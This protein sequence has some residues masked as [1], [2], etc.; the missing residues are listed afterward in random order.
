[1]DDPRS[2]AY[3]IEKLLS[4]LTL[5]SA[6]PRDTVLEGLMIWAAIVEC[7]AVAGMDCETCPIREV[8]PRVPKSQRQELS[9]SG[10]VWR[11]G[12]GDTLRRV[13]E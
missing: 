12:Q 1:M 6:L 5:T 4:I 2:P 10:R 11:E 7:D 8:C 3:R 13:I 9:P